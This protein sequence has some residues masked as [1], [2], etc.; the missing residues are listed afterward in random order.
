MRRY[1]LLVLAACSTPADRPPP[2]RP[3]NE[4]VVGDF[5]RKPPAGEMALRFGADGTYFFTKTKDEIDKPPHLADG[6]F[7]VEGDTLTFTA[8]KGMCADGQKSGSYK[9]VI[10]KVGIR[11]TKV[12]DGCDDRARLDGSTFWRLK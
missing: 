4:L 2:K 12:E 3:N 10:S 11:F 5:A 7:K 9:V 1:A 8:D 6:T